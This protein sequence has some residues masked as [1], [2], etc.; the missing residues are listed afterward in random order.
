MDTNGLEQV[1]ALAHPLRLRLLELFA[2]E[3]RT[4]KQAAEVLGEPP[5]RLYHHVAALER[6]GL[7]RLKETRKNRGTTE[8]YYEASNSLRP[9]R[10]EILKDKR[11]RR[12]LAAMGFVVFD[13]ARNELVK[14]LASDDVP[15]NLVALRAVFHLTAKEAT[16]LRKELL[17]VL[18]RLRERHKPP[19]AKRR[20]YSLTIALV[21]T[22]ES[23]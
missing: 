15:D 7:I 8:K 1:R 4:A 2:R 5:T 16:A 17:A 21:P 20:K 14:T 11:A 22:E 9:M 6:A 10:P 19:R 18:K 12:E 13:H 3:A 23:V